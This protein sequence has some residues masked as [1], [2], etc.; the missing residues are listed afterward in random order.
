VTSREQLIKELERAADAIVETVLDFFLFV[1]ARQS[2]KGGLSRVDKP[3]TDGILSLLEDV[4]AIQSQVPPTEWD[5]L[6]HDGS[7]N[8]DHY[9]YGAPKVE[10]RT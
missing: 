1:K 3:T 2:Q 4:R 5:K 10:N 6:P 9:L 8:Y 7:I